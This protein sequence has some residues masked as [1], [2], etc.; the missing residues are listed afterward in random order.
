MPTAQQWNASFNL[1]RTVCWVCQ[2]KFI[3]CDGDDPAV[4][5]NEHH[6]VPRAN[7]G[8][9]GPTVALCSAHH[10]L[11]HEIATQALC[12]KPF[13]HMTGNLPEDQSYRVMYL[14]KVV[15]DSTRAVKNDPNKRGQCT[16]VMD[17]A[18]DRMLN[19]LAKAGKCSR[20]SA[21]LS[22]IQKEYNRLFP[23]QTR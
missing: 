21:V 9:D 3:S 2:R 15:V 8:E 18:T 23:I 10:D 1:D 11:L 17:G 13:V 22:L 20:T 4:I 16:I 7:G 5:L 6:V 12:F 19:A 14:A